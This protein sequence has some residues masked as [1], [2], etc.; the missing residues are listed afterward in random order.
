MIKF[1]EFASY[2]KNLMFALLMALGPKYATTAPYYYIGLLIVGYG[3][4]HG[5]FYEFRYPV[6]GRV[7]FGIGEAIMYFLYSI[8]AA[9]TKDWFEK[10]YIDLFLLGI[11]LLLDVI[12][13]IMEGVHAYK[14]RAAGVE[15]I[16][17]NSD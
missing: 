12:Y 16:P 7:L 4:F 17:E 1:I 6:V 13:M 5:Y 14:N 11:I 8:Y 15:V 10:Y 2:M 9:D 3:G